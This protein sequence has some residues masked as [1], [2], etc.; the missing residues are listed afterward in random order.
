MI[1]AHSTRVSPLPG[2]D[3]DEKKQAIKH[4]R[5]AGIAAL[6]MECPDCGGACVAPD[7][8]Y[9]IEPSH[10]EV[11]CQD[12]GQ[13]LRVPRSLFERATRRGGGRHR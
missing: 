7:G 10:H 9:L 12:C 13:H 11:V 5:L 4:A 1:N 8:S 2:R 6:F 3:G